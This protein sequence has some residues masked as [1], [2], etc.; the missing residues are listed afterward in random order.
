[1]LHWIADQILDILN[2]VPELFLAKD[3]PR[4]DTLR[5]WIAVVFVIVLVLIFRR[6]WKAF[7]PKL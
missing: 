7:R 6:V 3:D 4:F 2:Y 5:W 1:M